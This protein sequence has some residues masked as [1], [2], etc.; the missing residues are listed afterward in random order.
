ML[1]ELALALF[2]LLPLPTMILAWGEPMAR[3]SA[4]SEN[5]STAAIGEAPVSAPSNVAIKAPE[6]S[7][8]VVYWYRLPLPKEC[9]GCKKLEAD[10]AAGMLPWFRFE[11]RPAPSWVTASPTVHFA[12][13]NGNW[14]SFTG[15]PGALEFAR[16]WGNKNPGNSLQLAQPQAAPRASGPPAADQAIADALHQYLGDAGTFELRPA[17]PIKVSIDN[18]TTLSYGV[19]RGRWKTENG[20][21]ILYFEEP[22][23][24]VETKRFLARIG[25]LIYQVA[26]VESIPPALRVGTSMG[27]W[28]FK[29]EGR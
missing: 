6:D 17:T 25:V 9:P 3:F 18:R 1:R 19:V 2:C 26:L 4:E 13:S 7:R 12:D 24:K 22:F 28:T 27:R 5:A 11:K 20:K 16:R 21:P 23:P 29:L 10:I 8:P 15:W 14:H